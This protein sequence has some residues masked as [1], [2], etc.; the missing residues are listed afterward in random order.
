MTDPLAPA[1]LDEW[2]RLARAAQR[3]REKLVKHGN[4]CDSCRAAIR[5]TDKALHAMLTPERI[6]GLIAEARRA[7]TDDERS[8]LKSVWCTAWEYSDERGEDFDVAHRAL[9]RIAAA[10]EERD[11]A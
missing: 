5:D 10:P 1:A 4:N 8:A 9:Q 6:L 2:E 7:L 11:D 3:A